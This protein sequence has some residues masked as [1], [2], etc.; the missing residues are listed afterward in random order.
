[1]RPV[2]KT[3][4]A[5]DEDGVDLTYA[6][7][8]AGPDLVLLHGI[9]ARWQVFSPLLARLS[10]RWRMLAPDFRGHGTSGR[11]PGRYRI[12]DFCEDALRVI[13]LADGGPPILYGHSLGGWVAL[14]VAARHPDRVRAVV[15]GDSAL[16]PREIDPEFAVSY[17]ANLPL[18]LRSLAK[19]LKQLDQDVLAHLRDGRLTAGFD[20]EVVLPAVTCP[21]LLLQGNP[22]RGAL[23]RDSDVEGA[24]RLLPDARHVKLGDLG[25]GL[26]VENAEQVIDAVVPFLDEVLRG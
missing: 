6:E 1:M 23:M 4:A 9:G 8:G 20:P 7:V 3:L 22:E 11:S 24:L 17:L 19:S 10:D 13:A 26:H 16:F 14:A 15:V 5:G 25:H 2:E 18:A 21:V 12:E